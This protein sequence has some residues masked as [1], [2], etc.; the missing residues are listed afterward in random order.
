MLSN[1]T[2][3]KVAPQYLQHFVGVFARDKIPPLNESAKQHGSTTGLSYIL[4]LQGEHQGDEKG[5]HWVAMFTGPTDLW[6]FDSYGIVAPKDVYNFC[7]HNGFQHLH[8][9]LLEFQKMGSP[10]CGEYCLY[11]LMK[12]EQMQRQ[13]R[14]LSHATVDFHPNQPT[15]NDAIIRQW[16]HNLKH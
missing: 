9:N 10:W 7:D 1:F 12:C 5:T 8:E 13:N 16:W 6:Y 11:W 4:N 14:S 3:E 15:I 2:L